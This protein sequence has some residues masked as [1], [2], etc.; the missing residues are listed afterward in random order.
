[1]QQQLHECENERVCV[2]QDLIDYHFHLRKRFFNITKFYYSLRIRTILQCYIVG[3]YIN[4]IDKVLLF[5]VL[6]R[7]LFWLSDLFGEK[8]TH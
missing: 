5:T 4:N 2:S 6:F 1:M 8:K 3:N 7:H